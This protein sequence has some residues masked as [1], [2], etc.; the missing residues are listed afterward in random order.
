MNCKFCNGENADDAVYCAHCG[1]RVNGTTDAAAAEATTNE[2]APAAAP[3]ATATEQQ[4]VSGWKKTVLLVGTILGLIGAIVSVIFVFLIGMTPYAKPSLGEKPSAEQISEII[5]D[6]IGI[7]W[8]FGDALKNLGDKIQAGDGQNALAYILRN[9]FPAMFG[10]LIFVG[11]VITVFVLTIIAIVRYAKVL[12]GKSSKGVEGITVGI[13]LTYAMG[14]AWIK[15]LFAFK[16]EN[17]FGKYGYALNGATIAGL[18]ISAVLVCALIATRIVVYGKDLL[19][20]GNILNLSF[21]AV[22]AVLVAVVWSL[23]TSPV[24]G[25]KSS[26]I[27][28][29]TSVTYSFLALMREIAEVNVEEIPAELAT[30]LS[31]VVTMGLWGQLLLFAIVPI[32]FTAALKNLHNAHSKNHKSTL[33]VAICL[34]VFSLFFLIAGMSAANNLYEYK[35]GGSEA[36]EELGYSASKIMT[37]VIVVFVMAVLNLGVSIADKV[38]AKKY[39]D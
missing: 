20:R 10:W 32:T 21:A 37:G 9:L 35:F 28:G 14:A 39:A 22:G 7:K 34:V 18:V 5:G 13:F 38:C 3:A 29:D 17:A 25:Y 15:A 31:T 33:A 2:A 30:H 36:L 6:N 1:K 19:K 27:M 8:F 24:V 11:I 12:S 4:P 23:S 26:S 16:A